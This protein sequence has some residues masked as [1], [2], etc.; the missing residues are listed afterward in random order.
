MSSLSG[1][2]I[3][4]ANGSTKDKFSVTQSTTIYKIGSGKLKLALVCVR[5]LQ[6]LAIVA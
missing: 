2:E 5:E 4:V 3:R 6:K 1:K